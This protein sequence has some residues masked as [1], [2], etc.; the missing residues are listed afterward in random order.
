MRTYLSLRQHERFRPSHSGGGQEGVRRGS[1]GSIS[2]DGV[3]SDGAV[4]PPH[5]RTARR[6]S[7]SSPTTRGVLL[8]RIPIY[9]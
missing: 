7:I 2:A 1:E 6:S 8:G 9:R 4:H 3:V 5:Y